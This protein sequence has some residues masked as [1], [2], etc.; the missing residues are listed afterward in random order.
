MALGTIAAWRLRGEDDKPLITFFRRVGLPVT[1][2]DLG[3]EMDTFLRAV[4]LGPGTRP[5]RWT[6]LQELSDSHVERL[7]NSYAGDEAVPGAG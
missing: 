7:R 5:D 4:R 1:P 6:S 3:I 2:S